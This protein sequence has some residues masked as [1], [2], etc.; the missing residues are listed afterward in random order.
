[1]ASVVA[2]LLMAG[3]MLGFSQAFEV[4]PVAVLSASILV[5]VLTLFDAQTLRQAWRYDQADAWSWLATFAGVLVVGVELGIGLGVVLSLAVLVWRS[6]RPHMAV[7]GRIAGT[8]HFRNI[9]RHQ[10]QTLP[11]LI[12]LR[13][14]ESL[15]FANAAALEEKV[16]DLLSKHSDTRSLLLILSAVNRI[17]TTALIM[18]DELDRSLALQGVSLSMA[19]VKG[20]V[21]DRLG[22][23]DLGRRLASRIYLSTNEAFN[24]HR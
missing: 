20:P 14:D 18:L 10:V 15:F 9:E 17:D 12:A 6:S 19:E 16:A 24:A 23:T 7:V 4:L 2:A 5:S 13:V 3:V 11:G 22:Q 1:M 8:E 21:M